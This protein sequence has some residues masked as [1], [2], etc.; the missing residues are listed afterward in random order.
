MQ[1]GE[2]GRLHPKPVYD[3]IR[4]PTYLIYIGMPDF[5]EETNARWRVWVIWWKLHVG[6]EQNK[7][8]CSTTLTLKYVSQNKTQLATAPRK[9]SNTSHR[10]KQNSLQ[11]HTNSE[12][13]L[14]DQTNSLQHHA[15]SEIRLTEQNTTR[16][17]TTQ[18]LKYLS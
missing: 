2:V 17:S 4:M 11:H 12:I 1:T 15:N 8:R 18:T 7:T 16:C 10:T 6:L 9:L 14:T 13:P 3:K 5:G